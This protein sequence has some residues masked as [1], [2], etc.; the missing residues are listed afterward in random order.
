MKNGTIIYLTNARKKNIHTLQTVLKMIK[1]I[2][3]TQNLVLLKIIFFLKFRLNVKILISKFETHYL[4]YIKELK[5]D[6]NNFISFFDVKLCFAKNSFIPV[7]VGEWN[8]FD[9]NICNCTSSNVFK[10]SKLKFNRPETN[11]VFSIHNYEC[12]YKCSRSK[13]SSISSISNYFKNYKSAT[14]IEPFSSSSIKKT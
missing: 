2:F 3:L 1:F 11:Q 14:W 4:Q 12:N 10:N 8:R 5:I 7:N 6:Q 9:T 13:L